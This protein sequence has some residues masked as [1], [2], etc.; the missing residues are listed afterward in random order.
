M[1]LIFK[2]IAF[3]YLCAAFMVLVL[4]EKSLAQGANPAPPE[5]ILD[6]APGD[7]VDPGPEF[8]TSP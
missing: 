5:T 3:A 8:A 7:T 2:K 6:F 4:K 1:N